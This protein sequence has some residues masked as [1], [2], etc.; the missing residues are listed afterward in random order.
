MTHDVDAQ[1]SQPDGGDQAADEDHKRRSPVGLIIAVVAVVALV[2][3]IGAWAISSNS[4]DDEENPIAG[5]EAAP[6]EDI[7]P[8]DDS[9]EQEHELEPAPGEREGVEGMAIT[10]DGETAPVDFVQVTDQGVLLP[11]QDV[12]RVGWYSAS[13]IPG[14][15]GEGSS[16]ITGHVNFAGQGEGFARRF[17][18]LA[19]GSEVIVHVNG[20]DRAFRVSE[21]P[22]HVT[23]GD[24]LP[25]V[26][27]QAEGDNRLVLITCGGE[28]VGGQLGYADNVITVA[29]PV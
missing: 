9:G 2:I 15:H 11:P 22:E 28:F 20:E 7:P 16:V 8:V 14:E 23:K 19:E 13:A 6:E 18:D 5:Q 25:E 12:S 17:V 3:G 1:H 26:V 29:D 27:N 4:G 10:V 21:P 24:A